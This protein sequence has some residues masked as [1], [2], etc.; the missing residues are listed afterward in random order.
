M[1]PDNAFLPRQEFDPRRRARCF[2]F[3]LVE[4][5]TV[6]AI[7]GILAAIIVP[8]ISKVRLSAK[9][10]TCLSRLRHLG[11]AFLVY[12]S[13]HKGLLPKASNDA[14]GRWPL[15]LAPYAGPWTH[16]FDS[17]GRLTVNG[18]SG[19]LY[20]NEIF[21]DPANEPGGGAVGTFGYNIYLEQKIVR[22]S[23]LSKPGTF[24]LLASSQGDVNGGMRLAPNGPSA[25]ARDYGWTGTTDLNGP[26][27]NYG[28]L[29]GFLFADGHVAARDV[30]DPNA[31][32]WRPAGSFQAK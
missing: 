17:Q 7:V 25:K 13:D 14:G 27:P 21:R 11:T 15:L 2:A 10:S 18:G 8:T 28:R 23:D 3:T 6:I 26:A 1:N 19:Q 29:A 4:L 31:W 32:P 5:L 30:C 12:G 22:L 9:K 20:N 24:P 16:T